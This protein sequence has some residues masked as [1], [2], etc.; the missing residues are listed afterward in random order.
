[1]KRVPWKD[2]Q[3]EFK[4]S[5]KNLFIFL[6]HKSVFGLQSEAFSDPLQQ[7]PLQ[8]ILPAC[9]N[10]PLQLIP[11]ETS[12]RTTT[13]QLLSLQGLKEYFEL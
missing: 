6:R 2:R 3:S 11:E 4:V 13:A 1:M 7:G 8:E 5:N 10:S 12:V 9:S